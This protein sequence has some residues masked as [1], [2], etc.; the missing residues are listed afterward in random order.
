MSHTEVLIA[1]IAGIA[2]S[3]CCGFRIFI[4]IL[5][6]TFGV[7][8]GFLPHE[9]I[10]EASVELIRNDVFTAAIT[11]ATVLEIAAYKIPFIDNFLDTIATPLA[12]VAATLLSSSF[13]T[14]AEDSYMR[15]I[16]GAITGGLGAGIIQASTSAIRATSSQWTAGF[17]NPIFGLIETLTAFV[18]SLLSVL[19]PLI[20]IAL[21]LLVCWGSLWLLK[22]LFK[23]RPR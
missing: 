22:R 15:F 9:W 5:I 12:V 10:N 8:F 2:L 1:I 16:L 23:M 14:F 6:A 7:R 20:G 4:P 11:V 13:F 21:I 17:G 19:F 18:A 3:A